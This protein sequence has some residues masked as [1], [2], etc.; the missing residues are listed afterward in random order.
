MA[1]WVDVEKPGQNYNFILANRRPRLPCPKN[2]EPGQPNH[3]I[4]SFL[5]DPF[6]ENF[7]F[8]S[9]SFTSNQISPT[10]LDRRL[11]EGW[12]HFGSYFFRY[13]YNWVRG[14]LALVVPLRIRLATYLPSRS[15]RKVWQKNTHFQTVVRPIEIDQV[16]IAL[17]DK[18]KQ[19]FERNVPESLATFL[20]PVRPHECPCEA[21]AV[22][23]YDGQRLIACSFLDLGH[24][25]VSSVY[26]MFDPDYEKF[27]LG[28]YTVL[29]ELEHARQNG[30]IF[31]YHGYSYNVPTGYDYKKKFAG[32]EKYDW[33]GNWVAHLPYD[34]SPRPLV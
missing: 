1:V 8:I 9:D 11:A 12:R 33:Q 27:S 18:H 6:S 32:L 20:S 29:L 14:E 2:P 31:Y 21:V 4:M 5:A 7:P 13:S 34:D 16:K 3:Q 25:A 17:F 15:Q 26:A 22:E 28:I 10:E 19:R 24:A 23:V 30:K